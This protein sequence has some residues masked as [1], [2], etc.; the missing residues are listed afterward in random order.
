MKSP[1]GSGLQPEPT[2]LFGIL[3]LYANDDVIN[4]IKRR[5]HVTNVNPQKLS[6]A[7]WGEGGGD[8]ETTMYNYSGSGWCEYI[9]YHNGVWRF[10]LWPDL[11]DEQLCSWFFIEKE[12]VRL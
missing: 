1:A 10:S 12:V 4:N 11:Q 7:G 5:V 6:S 8:V 9:M 3:A 2:S